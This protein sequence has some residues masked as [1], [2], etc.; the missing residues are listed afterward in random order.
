MV[1]IQQLP[2]GQLTI[3]LPKALAN[4]KGWKKGMSVTYKDHSL[5]SLIIEVK[6]D[7]DESDD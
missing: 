7:S 1:K 3:T 2:N 6:K 5:S 4:L